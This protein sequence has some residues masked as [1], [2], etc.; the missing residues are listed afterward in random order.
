MWTHFVSRTS[1]NEDGDDN[2]EAAEVLSV[3]SDDDLSCEVSPSGNK[4]V[5]FLL[6]TITS[7]NQLARHISVLAE[8]MP[9]RN[10]VEVLVSVFVGLIHDLL[11]VCF[12]RHVAVLVED[13]KVTIKRGV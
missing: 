9:S 7:V 8:T 3:S 1:G 5:V 2:L 13:L 12:P 10:G 4:I 6:G 11:E